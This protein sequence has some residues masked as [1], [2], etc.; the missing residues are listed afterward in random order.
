MRVHQRRHCRKENC[1]HLFQDTL[2]TSLYSSKEL[3]DHIN[4]L[5]ESSHIGKTQKLDPQLI[6]IIEKLI[7]SIFFDTEDLLLSYR[8]SEIKC[9]STQVKLWIEDSRRLMESAY[10]LLEH[11][12]A[13]KCSSSPRDLCLAESNFTSLLRVADLNLRNLFFT[14]LLFD[15]NQISSCQRGEK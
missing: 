13:L 6:G 11:I 5:Y 7:E 3:Q 4:V 2:E 15:C 14:D 10:D 1:N 8:P 12:V 9:D